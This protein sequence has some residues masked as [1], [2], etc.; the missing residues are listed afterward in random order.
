MTKPPGANGGL[1]EI[2]GKINDAHVLLRDP[3]SRKSPNPPLAPVTEGT[4]APLAL[5]SHVPLT[6]SA[7]AIR[8]TLLDHELTLWDEL[9]F[10]SDCDEI[11]EAFCRLE[12]ECWCIANILKT[13]PIDQRIELLSAGWRSVF[14]LIASGACSVSYALSRTDKIVRASKLN[15]GKRELDRAVELILIGPPA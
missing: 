9:R 1:D 3:P 8:D 15:L 11:S 5:A 7:V 10:D 13:A 14:P 6:P 2:S 4:S 12:D